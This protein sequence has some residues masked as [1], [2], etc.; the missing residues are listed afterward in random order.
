MGRAK[1]K[2]RAKVVARNSVS[3]FKLLSLLSVGDTFAYFSCAIVLLQYCVSFVP[4]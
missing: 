3:Y 4:D 2:L 1:A